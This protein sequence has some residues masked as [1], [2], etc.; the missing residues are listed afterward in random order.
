MR[1]TLLGGLTPRAFLAHHWQRRPL[2][3][4]GAIPGFRD[5]LQIADLFRLAARDDTESR[6]VRRPARK[7][8]LAHGPFSRAALERM[9][10]SRW[11]LL[12]QGVNHFVPAVD[13]LMRRF[14]FASYAVSTTSW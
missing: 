2:V 6:L 13:R 14:A 7:W 4:R 5:P 11:T 12:V 8:T 10:D 3:V 1:F 9:P